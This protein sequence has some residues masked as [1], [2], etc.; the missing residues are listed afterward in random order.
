MAWFKVDDGLHASRKLLSIPRTVRLS[1]LG[2][3]TIAGSWSAHEELDG[4]VPD[5]MVKEWGGTPRLVKA[6]V[7]AGLWEVVEGGNRFGKW[8]EYQPTRADLDAARESERLRKAEYRRR[9]KGES[10]PP[11]VPP[12]QTE[13]HQRVSGH[14]DP[15]R[16]DPTRPDPFP[17]GKEGGTPTPFCSNHPFGTDDPCRA[18]GDARKA[19]KAA[20]EPAAPPPPSKPNRGPATCEQHYGYP[21]PC[22]R[23]TEEREEAA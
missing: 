16:P 3:W 20:G 19:W 12:G 7:D 11:D 15:T 9:K 17:K 21:L 5:F 6:L 4:F 2:L 14:P 22:D 13:G 18:C 10:V 23:C 8:A 1:A